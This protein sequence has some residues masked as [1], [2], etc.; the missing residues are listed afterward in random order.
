MT[1]DPP[2]TDDESIDYRLENSQKLLDRVARGREELRAGGGTR[3][4]D[5]DF[6][7]DS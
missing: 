3:L 7:E 4:E 2:I 1:D 5:L 6:G